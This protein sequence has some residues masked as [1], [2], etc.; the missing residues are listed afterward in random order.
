MSPAV[1]WKLEG[2]YFE[3]CDCNTVC[4]CVYMGPPDEV[5]CHA[6]VAWHITKGHLGATKLDGLNV[7]AMFHS[8]GHMVTGPKW[9]AALYLD[10]RAKAP[11]ADALGKIFSGQAGGFLGE[12]AKFIGS[13]KGVKSV[14][15]EFRAKGR[16]RTVR[17][18]EHV[19]LEIEAVKGMNE[20]DEPTLHN[21]T[22]VVAPGFD[23]V[24]AQSKRYSYRD[25]G[26]AIELSGKN[27]FYSR[28]AYG[29]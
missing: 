25:H 27:G 2:D 14:P 15:I 13:V 9:N 16:S 18:P 12:V 7:V 3:G 4:P 23:P 8:P 29:P 26:Y 20:K 1:A 24:V 22:F 21:P 17:V 19:D 28:F 6:T 11:Q 10:A 5:S